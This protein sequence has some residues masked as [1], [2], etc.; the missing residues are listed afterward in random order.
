LVTLDRAKPPE[1]PAHSVFQSLEEAAV[2]LKY[3]PR[4]ISILQDGSAKRVAIQRDEAAWK[5][6][7]VEVVS[8][9]WTFFQEKTVRPEICY[10]V[11]PISYQWNR[12]RV[13]A[14]G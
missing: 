1:L 7:L 11:A 13:M 10:E 8:A 14:A 2:F 5:Y 12:G 3:K 4:G 6:R 9:D